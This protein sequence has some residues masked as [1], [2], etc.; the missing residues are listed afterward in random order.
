MSLTQRIR[1]KPQ[2]KINNRRLQRMQQ[3][4]RVGATRAAERIGP[5]AGQ[6][7]EIATER[8]TLARQW[9]APK[10]ERAGRF[11][12][13]DLAPRV[14]SMLSST[15]RRVEPARAKSRRVRKIAM[16]M[17]AGLLAVGAIGALVS[18]RNAANE[19]QPEEDVAESEAEPAVNGQVHTK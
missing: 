11:V 19:S 3:Q 6:A 7:R 2:V 4:T 14:N 13:S 17:I 12:E 16:V 18:K 9:S 1:R 10:L 5:T 8:V 15:A